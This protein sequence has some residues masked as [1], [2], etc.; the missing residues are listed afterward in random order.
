LKNGN[1]QPSNSTKF[2][3]T[4]YGQSTKPQSLL[5]PQDKRNL[6]TLTKVL[7]NIN[8]RQNAASKY[9][10]YRL[11]YERLQAIILTR[12]REDI[13]GLI[14]LLR[15]GLVRN[16]GNITAFRL[17]DRAYAG[18]KLL[19]EDYITQVTLAIDAVA[20]YSLPT[21]TSQGRGGLSS[22][23]KLDFLH[24]TR[25]AF[26]RTA[27]VLQGG[28]VFGLCHAGVVKALALRGLLPR[29][30][31]GSGAGALVAAVVGVC[32]EGELLEF[33]DRLSEHGSAGRVGKVNGDRGSWLWRY[34]RR[35]ERCVSQGYFLDVVV[36]EKCVLDTVGD[37]TFEEAYSRTRKVL[38]ISIPDDYGH[39]MPSLFNYL[40][41][42]NVVSLQF[43][44]FTAPTPSLDLP[45]TPFPISSSAQQPPPQTALPPRLHPHQSSSKRPTTQ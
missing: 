31:V 6:K 8:R 30:V 7:Y 34:W 39:G 4:I 9:Y 44:R 17:Y 35:L 36:L 41:T 10:D 43:S 42:P 28:A 14:N 2:W 12:E 1:R 11:I 3:V 22:Q 5:P 45:L 18:T 27:L 20:A 25:Q 13:L 24:D 33:L 23:S 38:N 26:G 37:V 19:I 21:P 15:S 32:G 29:I 40:T 16:L